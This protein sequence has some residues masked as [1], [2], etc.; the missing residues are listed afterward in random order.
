M[1]TKKKLFLVWDSNYYHI[2]NFQTCTLVQFMN[3]EQFYSPTRVKFF[4]ALIVRMDITG[5]KL[6][7]TQFVQ[8]LVFDKTHKLLIS[9]CA[10][11]AEWKERI[12]DIERKL[13]PSENGFVIFFNTSYVCVFFTSFSSVRDCQ[14]VAVGQFF[15]HL[16]QI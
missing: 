10:I 8:C 11:F 9:L 7:F 15:H 5:T 12:Q 4:F 3:T 13:T 6:K 16:E 1:K 2:I 14:V